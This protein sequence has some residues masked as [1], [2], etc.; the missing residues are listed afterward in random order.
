MEQPGHPRVLRELGKRLDNLVTSESL[1][2][3]ISHTD[4]MGLTGEHYDRTDEDEARWRLVWGCERKLDEVVG[5][6]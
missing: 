5:A 6:P 2:A 1:R 4:G 3:P